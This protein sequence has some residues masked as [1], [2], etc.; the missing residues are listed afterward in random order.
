MRQDAKYSKI[1]ST[2]DASVQSIFDK[3]LALTDNLGILLHQF[4]HLLQCSRDESENLALV[5]ELTSHIM[6]AIQEEISNQQSAFCGY[7]DA[8]LGQIVY[9]LQCFLEPVPPPECLASFIRAPSQPHFPTFSSP[10]TGDLLDYSF[11]ATL[12]RLSKLAAWIR[13][14][15]PHSS[16]AENG[17]HSRTNCIQEAGTS[18]E[19]MQSA[20]PI[21]NLSLSAGNNEQIGDILSDRNSPETCKEAISPFA[22]SAPIAGKLGPNAVPDVQL[23]SLEVMEQLKGRL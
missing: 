21:S 1:I 6:G 19:S 16:P 11:E 5:N 7:I 12:V 14:S 20:G 4:A 2:S 13:Q 8:I 18:L 17:L 10:R 15:V 23:S 9:F 3:G 22:M